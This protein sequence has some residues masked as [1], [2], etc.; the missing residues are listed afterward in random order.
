MDLALALIEIFKDTIVTFAGLFI[1][2]IILGAAT[3]QLTEWLSQLNKWR[4]DILKDAIV[5]IFGDKYLTDKF[6]EHPLIRSFYGGG[7]KDR[8]SLIPGEYFATVVFDLILKADPEVSA[9]TSTATLSPSIIEK[10]RGNIETLKMSGAYEL[11]YLAYA[12]DN[13]LVDITPDIQKADTAIAEAR[14]RVKNWYNEIVSRLGEEYK[15][16]IQPWFI[17]FGIVLAALINADTLAI[18]NHLSVQPSSVALEQSTQAI[19]TALIPLG[20]VSE[21]IPHNLSGWLVKFGGIIFSGLVAAEIAPIWN[22]L[23]RRILPIQRSTKS[24]AGGSE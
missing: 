24:A 11:G 3:S 16:K 1:V 10:L 18:V 9:Q 4:A 7:G 12:I 13:L 23:I 2:W 15:R 22:D 17:I 19:K 5:N 20:W 14:Q 6:Y 8:P 21:N